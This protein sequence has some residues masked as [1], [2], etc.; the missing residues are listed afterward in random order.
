MLHSMRAIAW[1]M[2]TTNKG[3]PAVVRNAGVFACA[4]FGQHGDTGRRSI[5]EPR[6]GGQNRPAHFP[7]SP[8]ETDREGAV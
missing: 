5:R 1:Y 4:T 3:I 2:V 8:K 7:A 6:A